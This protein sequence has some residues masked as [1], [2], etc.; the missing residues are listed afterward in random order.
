MYPNDAIQILW[1]GDPAPALV[2]YGA[3]LFTH[4]AA[5]QLDLP[6]SVACLVAVPEILGFYALLPS[7]AIMSSLATQPFALSS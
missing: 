6:L 5:E 3:C 4:S 1:T 7:S 2:Q